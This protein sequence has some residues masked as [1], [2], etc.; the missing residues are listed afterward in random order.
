MGG[1]AK[2]IEA[3]I[4]KLRIE[5]AAARTQARI[6]TGEQAVIGVNKY[7]AG[8][9]AEID[10]L[11]VDNS[12]VR[13]R[14]IEKLARLEAEA[15]CA[16]LPGGARPSSRDCPRAAKAISSPPPSMRRAPGRRS[17][18]CRWRWKEPGAGMPPEVRAVSGVYAEA[19][20]RR[21]KLETARGMRSR[22]SPRATAG[23][24]ASSSPRSARTAMTAAR[25]SSRRLSPIMGFDVRIGPLFAT[26]EE[27]AAAAIEGDVHVVGISSLTAG[28]M[29]LISGLAGGA[30]R[31]RRPD[32]MIVVGGIV[33]PEDVQA[34][35]R[36]ACWR[37]SRPAPRS[38]SGAHPARRLN[39]HLGYAQKAAE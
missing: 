26:P 6:D 27:V 12:A 29:T 31:R 1:M 14:Q 4:P 13:A 37:S 9:R 35:R 15:R 17:A 11:K 24:R 19:S 5:E 22:L 8:E 36:W 23:R 10:I 30:R 33:P 3:G 20:P 28:H 25:R 39:E 2:A 34:L 21:R 16:G 32:I 18:R 38:P 7:R